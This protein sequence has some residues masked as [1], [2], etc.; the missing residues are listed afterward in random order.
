MD[1]LWNLWQRIGSSAL[2]LPLTPFQSPQLIKINNIDFPSR[3]K[4]ITGPTVQFTAPFDFFGA[5]TSP[6]VTLDYAMDFGQLVTG[7]PTINVSEVMDI[8]AG[9]L[10]YTYV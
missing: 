4:D 3:V 1:R 7:S 6:N 9:R 8:Q 10:C 5:A 2:P